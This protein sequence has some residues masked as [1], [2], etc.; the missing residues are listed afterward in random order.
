MPQFISGDLVVK[1]PAEFDCQVLHG[2]PYCVIY[3]NIKLKKKRL[4][5]LDTREKLFYPL[6]EWDIDDHKAF[7]KWYEFLFSINDKIGKEKRCLKEEG[8]SMFELDKIEQIVP[9][10]DKMIKNLKDDNWSVLY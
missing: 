8:V 2:T 7:E 5:L 9:E 4:Y 6:A 10:E 3:Q 1:S